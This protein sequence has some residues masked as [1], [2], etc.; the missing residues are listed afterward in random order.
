MTLLTLLIACGIDHQLEPGFTSMLTR[1]MACTTSQ[2]GAVD[3]HA[4]LIDD[5]GT[6][7]MQIGSGV[8]EEEPSIVVF[9]GEKLGAVWGDDDACDDYGRVTDRQEIAMGW[10]QVAG[11]VT[12]TNE[13]GA[14]SFQLSGVVLEPDPAYDYDV[15]YGDAADYDEVVLPD[16]TIGPVLHGGVLQALP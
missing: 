9:T 15:F 4:G 7:R 1:G 6:V 13:D 10:T 5:A 12:V 3:D 16:Q 2:I 11:E 8:S 14:R